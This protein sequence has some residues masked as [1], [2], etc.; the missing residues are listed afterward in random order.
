M[1]HGSSAVTAPC[2]ACLEQPDQEETKEEN[3]KKQF[4]LSVQE[5]EET[6]RNN[7]CDKSMGLNK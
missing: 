3:A 4:W 5:V 6:Q 1:G 7:D 2:A